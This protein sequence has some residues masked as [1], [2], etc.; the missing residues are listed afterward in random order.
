MPTG[1]E[2]TWVCLLW[3]TPELQW[4]HSKGGIHQPDEIYFWYQ[5][6]GKVK[7]YLI[8]NTGLTCRG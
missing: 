7:H 1:L 3:V 8:C 4:W 5:V 2:I 6:T